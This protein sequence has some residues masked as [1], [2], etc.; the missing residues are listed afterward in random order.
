MIQ[1]QHTYQASKT[2]LLANLEPCPDLNPQPG[3][4]IPSIALCLCEGGTT[5]RCLVLASTLALLYRTPCFRIKSFLFLMRAF[6]S[7]GIPILIFHF[8]YSFVSL[9]SSTI[10]ENYGGPLTGPDT[11]L[12]V[13]CQVV[14]YPCIRHPPLGP[15]G[16][17]FPSYH[18]G[19]GHLY[20]QHELSV[21]LVPLLQAT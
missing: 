21:S 7:E 4:D 20:R 10:W 6:S 18:E 8:T 3:H 19:L 2:C 12:R 1:H 16:R 17:V 5:N 9:F 11:T 14:L 15:H 13:S